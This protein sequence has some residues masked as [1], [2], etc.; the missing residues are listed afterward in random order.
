[1]QR[2]APLPERI[3][4]I[5]VIY[6]R[7]GRICLRRRPEKGLLAGLWECPSTPWFPV[8]GDSKDAE[9][10]IA[11][12][13]DAIG[14]S[15]PVENSAFPVLFTLLPKDIRHIFSHFRLTVRIFVCNRPMD[16]ANLCLPDCEWFYPDALP[17]LST[18]ARKTIHAAG[19]LAQELQDRVE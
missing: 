12:H 3:C 7:Q 18:L 19:L 11:S 15:L 9:N 10:A 2:R 14:A 8:S 16:A 17:A 6:D 13:R 5:Y 4:A 1:M